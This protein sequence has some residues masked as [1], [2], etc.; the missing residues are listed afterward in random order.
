MLKPSLAAVAITLC[1][2]GAVKAEQIPAHCKPKLANNLT[3]TKPK[4]GDM[5]F[6]TRF[7]YCWEGFDT[8]GDG[9]EDDY[10]NYNVPVYWVPGTKLTNNFKMED[11]FETAMNMLEA[12]GS[13][14]DVLTH[15]YINLP[16]KQ[17]YARI[18]GILESAGLVDV[19][20]DENDTKDELKNALIN[21][22]LKEH[23]SSFNKDNSYKISDAIRTESHVPGPKSKRLAA[24]LLY[25]LTRAKEFGLLKSNFT[26]KSAFNLIISA[27]DNNNTYAK[28]R[29]ELSNFLDAIFKS[30]IL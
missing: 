3:Y 18:V 19:N 8:D 21:V 5:I 1:I 29:R 24:N 15:L 23:A 22:I 11:K 25:G 6:E 17:K 10:K 30:H 4:A 14:F 7:N 27:L 20:Y 12:R 13:F 2:S 26:V 28:R 16:N 9:Y